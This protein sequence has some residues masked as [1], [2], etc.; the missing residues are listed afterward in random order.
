MSDRTWMT[1]PSRPYSFMGIIETSLKSVDNRV[2]NTL[3]GRL[4]QGL[5]HNG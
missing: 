1:V 2:F 4:Y 5:P 3:S